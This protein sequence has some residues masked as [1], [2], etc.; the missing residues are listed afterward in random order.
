[1][2]NLKKIAIPVAVGIVGLAFLSSCAVGIPKG[3]TAVQNFDSQKYL[4][5]W[6]EIARFDFRFERGLNNVTA[7]YSM[8]DNGNIKV[9]NKGYNFEKKKWSESIGEA[10]FVDNYNVARLK[11]SFFKP[12]WAGYNVIDMDENYKYALVAGNN[13]DYLWI[14]SREKT[15]PQE[16]KERFLEKAE[17]IGYDTSKLIWV[18]HDK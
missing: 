5:K 16:Y 11:V 9:D 13:L 18:E 14:L 3:A 2:I 1:M 17:S 15:I 8:K 6:Y 7:T 10:Q 4:G 12:I